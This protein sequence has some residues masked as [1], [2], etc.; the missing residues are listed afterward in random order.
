MP[1]TGGNSMKN[2]K[3]AYFFSTIVSESTKNDEFTVE[4]SPNT[5]NGET[6]CLSMKVTNNFDE[7]LDFLDEMDE[8]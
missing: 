8:E 1:F 2:I 3:Q 4:F 6:E 7:L 5:T